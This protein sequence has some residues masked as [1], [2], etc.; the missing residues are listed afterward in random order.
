[1]YDHELVPV[2]GTDTLAAWQAVPFQYSWLPERWIVSERLRLTFRQLP[3]T[4]P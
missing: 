2:A 4:C 1:V 3:G